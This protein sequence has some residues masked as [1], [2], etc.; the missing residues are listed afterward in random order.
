M[1]IKGGYQIIEIDKEL[2][3]GS[4]GDSITN[5]SIKKWL[6]GI[7]KGNLN[8]LKPIL[9]KFTGQ[10][11]FKTIVLIDDS[12]LEESG[13]IIL[14]M[15]DISV[16]DS[17]YSCYIQLTFGQNEDEEYDINLLENVYFCSGEY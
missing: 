5:E 16:Q 7:I 4:M 6:H 8:L 2:E 1:N 3:V 11:L 12:D 15:E 9:F 17:N 10:Q 14:Y 13:N